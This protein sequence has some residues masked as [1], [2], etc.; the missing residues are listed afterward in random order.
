MN[1]LGMTLQRTP[2]PP[3]EI[4]NLTIWITWKVNSN[5]NLNLCHLLVD[6]R[7]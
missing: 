7:L 2:R 4:D 3:V 6:L 1:H 5:V